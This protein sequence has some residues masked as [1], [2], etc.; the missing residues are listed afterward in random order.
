MNEVIELIQSKILDYS[1]I[2]LAASQ[3]Q[4]LLTHLDKKA[5]AKGM[6]TIDYCRGLSPYTPDFDEIINLI[7][8]NETYF[9]REELQFDFLKKEVFSKNM[10]KNLTI[11]TCCWFSPLPWAW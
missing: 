11:W 1:G 7:T 2:N 3:H 8:V 10:G 5:S 9:F 4:P 6:L